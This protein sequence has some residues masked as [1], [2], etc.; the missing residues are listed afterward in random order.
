MP[1]ERIPKQILKY[2]LKDCGTTGD[3]GKDGMSEDGTGFS[4]IR[5]VKNNN[6]NNLTQSHYI[7]TLC[8]T[9]TNVYTVQR[10]S[11]LFNYFIMLHQSVSLHSME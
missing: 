1:D 4:L 10:I 5:E 2:K 6:N 3:L 8:D 11:C 7:L 9:A